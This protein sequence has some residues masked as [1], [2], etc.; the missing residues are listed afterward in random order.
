M[1]R[2]VNWICGVLAVGGV[3]SSIGYFLREPYNTGFLEHPLVVASHV[4]LG[5]GYLT[6][7]PFQFVARVR[8]RWPAYH[9]AV[10]RVLAACGVAVGASAFF[11]SIVIPYSGWPERIVNGAFSLYFT[12]SLVRAFGY[13]RTR[14][15]DLHR[16]WMIRAFS[17]GLAISTMRVL[18]IPSLVVFGPPTEQ[19]AA[20]LSIV[21]FTLAFLIHTTAAEWWIRR[22]RSGG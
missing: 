21:S 14:R 1:Q 12:V 7:A 9:R 10:G 19:L 2:L 20:T 4:V 6:F 22:T 16:E 18:F 5:A 11:I 15:I 13:A 3:G 8:E 17:I